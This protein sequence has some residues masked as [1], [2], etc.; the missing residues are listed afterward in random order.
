MP[1]TLE[2]ATREQEQTRGS[3]QQSLGLATD[4]AVRV[5]QKW[6][7]PQINKWRLLA[8][9]ISFALVEAS[10]GALVPYGIRDYKLFTTV[11]SLIFVTP[12]AGYAIATIIVNKTLMTFGQRGIAMIGPLCHILPFVVMAIHPPYPV[13]LVAYIIVGL[14]NGLIDAAWNSWTADMINANTLMG[15][16]N[17]FYGLRA[18]L[19]PTIATEMIKADL[20]WNFFYYTLLGPRTYSR[21]G[22]VL[23]RRRN[24]L[25]SR[26]P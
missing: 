15:F 14:G 9:F 20:R 5:K 1:T 6:N 7:N 19:S 13:M 10:D 23:A 26:E 22:Y 18:T 25:P 21:H 16:L 12:F 2:L 11:I 17:A 3:S 24:E 8:T 4:D